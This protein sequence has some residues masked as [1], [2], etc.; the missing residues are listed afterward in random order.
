M[1][2]AAKEKSRQA[3]ERHAMERCVTAD[4]TIDIPY[5]D[6]CVA[7]AWGDRTNAM[8]SAMTVDEAIALSM[9]DCRQ[10]SGDCKTVY[11]DCSLAE[12]IP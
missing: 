6:Q 4:C 2:V 1:G 7:V 3:A 5:H 12:P 9:E 11:I 10:D 8:A